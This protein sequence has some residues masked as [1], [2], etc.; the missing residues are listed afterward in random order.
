MLCDT[1]SEPIKS[2][3]EVLTNELPDLRDNRGKRHSLVVVIVAFVLATLR[4]RVTL[5]GVHRFM[6]NFVDRLHDL[7]KTEKTRV[8]SRAH[9]PRLLARLDWSVLDQLIERCFGLRISQDSVTKVWVAVDGKTLR[10][11]LHGD[12]KQSLVLAVTHETREVVGQSRQMGSKSRETLNN[13]AFHIPT[14]SF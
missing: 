14:V 7:T 11:T 13:S 12:E 1:H 4:G 5:S 9:L 6:V 2:F 3:V 8:I 10:G